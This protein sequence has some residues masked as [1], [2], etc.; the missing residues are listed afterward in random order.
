[1][2]TANPIPAKASSLA[3]LAIDTTMPTTTP[4]A[5]SSGPPELPGLTD[6]SNWM[7]PE[8]VPSAVRAVRSRPETTPTDTLSVRPI[9]FPMASTV[10]PTTARSPRTAGTTTPGS[11]A[12]LST[13]TSSLGLA[14]TT[15]A[16]VVVPS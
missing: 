3:G 4:P 8:N 14:D 2:G 1:M 15:A 12:G 16:C 7:S 10:A 5:S 6:A 11:D 9:G 13:A